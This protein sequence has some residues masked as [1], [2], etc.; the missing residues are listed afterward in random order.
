[1]SDEPFRLRVRAVDGNLRDAGVLQRYFRH[2]QVSEV[3]KN[4]FVIVGSEKDMASVR[5]A[6]A[7]AG[8]SEVTGDSEAVEGPKAMPHTATFASKQESKQPNVGK[9]ESL[10]NKPYG[11]V[12]LPDDLP[13]SEPIWHEG[14]HGREF[15]SGELRFEMEALTPLL[16]GCDRQQI[17][18]SVPGK[19]WPIEHR[20]D[21]SKAAEEELQAA[22][23]R[24]FPDATD[25][26]KQAR[27]QRQRSEYVAR[28]RDQVV[29]VSLPDVSPRGVERVIAR[30][31]RSK[32][33]LAPLR[34]PWGERPVIIPGDS[35]KGLLRQELGALLGAPME[36]VAERTYSYRPNLKFPDSPRNRVLEPRLA[37]VISNTSVTVMGAEY[38][39]PATVSVLAMAQRNDQRYYPTRVGRDIVS[40]PSDAEPYRGGMGAGERLPDVCLSSDAKSRLIHTHVDASQIETERPSAQTKPDVLEQYERTLRHLLDARFGHFSERHPQ[41]G[42]SEEA[43]RTARHALQEAARRAFQPGDICWIEWDKAAQQVVSFG[44]HYYYRWAYLDTVRRRGWETP[45]EGLHPTEEETADACPEGL[46]PVRRL[47]GYSGD[48][49]GSAG[50]GKQDHSQLMG[51]I[52]INAALEVINSGTSERDRFLE[53]TFLKELGMPRPSAVEYYVQQDDRIQSRPADRAELVT[54]G[55]AVGRD[56]PGRL[57]GRKFYLD[58]ADAYNGTAPWRDDSPENRLNERSTLALEAS[59]HGRRFRFTLRFRDI[60]RSELAAILLAF[61]PDQFRAV[62]GGKYTHGYCSKLGYARP[63]GWGSVRIQAKELHFL[64]LDADESG[65]ARLMVEDVDAWFSSNHVPQPMLEPWLKIHQHKHPDAD[66]YP[67][68]PPRTGPIYAYHSRLRA[69][70]SQS[71]RY[72]REDSR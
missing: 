5:S 50:I 48:N 12:P 56:T 33:C 16:V 25:P 63:L 14:A 57:S 36:R 69:E 4:E 35:L 51:R 43:R 29:Q 20:S 18:D 37:R 38:P 27:V 72:E 60:E 67:R 34:A 46:T 58:R 6:L 11:F 15:L 54:Y 30:T 1:M 55:D 62:V 39:A 26:K 41:V 24:L 8:L 66:D 71:R 19:H 13:V 10:R 7:L 64:T 31:V 23:V 21:T 70:H 40:P 3:G 17:G 28:L 53:P 61:C 42:G 59:Q 52:S 68:E 44:W 45:R 47:F 2:T 65:L 49:E 22:A 9:S 32:S